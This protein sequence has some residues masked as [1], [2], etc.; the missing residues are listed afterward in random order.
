[1]KNI[2]QYKNIENKLKKNQNN[3]KNTKKN[4]IF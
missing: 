2:S 1:M 4:G 3:K